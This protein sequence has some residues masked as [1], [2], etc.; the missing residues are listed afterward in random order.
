MPLIVLCGGPCSGK[1]TFA[2]QIK[3]HFEKKNHIVLLINEETLKVNKSDIYKDNISEK[4]HRS[5]L[6]SEVE[7]NIS[8]KTITIIDS[9]NY[10]KGSRYEFYCLVRNSKTRHCVIYIKTSLEKCIENN[11]KNKEYEINLLKDL[12]SRMEEPIQSNRWDCPL[13]TLYPNDEVP[14][15]DINISL[16]EGKKPKD[17]ISTKPDIAFDSNFLFQLDK[18]C[19]DIINDILKQQEQGLGNTII[20]I[21][22][23]DVVYLNKVFTA[24]ELKK[25]KMEFIKISK[26]L[27]PKNKEETIKNFVEYIVTVQDRY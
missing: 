8:D 17:P 10:F 13:Y 24:I 2:N 12:Y 7:K 25:I 4:N 27:P 3:E 26:N 20:K 11:I 19:Q 14:F 9:L 21:K 22:D 23:D 5:L 18:N 16:F 6:K 15:D 1:T